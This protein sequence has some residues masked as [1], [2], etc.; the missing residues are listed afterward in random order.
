M[1]KIFGL[2]LI[3]LMMVACGSSNT[4]STSDKVTAPETVEPAP[5]PIVPPWEHLNIQERDYYVGEILCPEATSV[6][7]EVFT[8]WTLYNDFRESPTITPGGTKLFLQVW[9][10]G[11]PVSSMTFLINGDTNQPVMAVLEL[12]N[13]DG[14]VSNYTL[15]NYY[16]TK[17]MKDYLEG[18]L[19]REI[20]EDDVFEVAKG[21][22]FCLYDPILD[23]T[24]YNTSL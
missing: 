12:G 24:I 21:H 18:N 6:V 8:Y 20:D 11:P 7:E 2:I 3:A 10:G 17:L 1:K 22:Y 23:D 13:E 5:N 15:L 4:T 14:S 19:N 16:S 9:I